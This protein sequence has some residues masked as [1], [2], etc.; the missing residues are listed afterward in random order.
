MND[1]TPGLATADDLELE[2]LNFDT[3]YDE[4]IAIEQAKQQLRPRFMIIERSL[5]AQFPDLS[6]VK[7]S[8]EI[9]Y[10][11]FITAMDGLDDGDS[12]GQMDALLTLM[13]P[14]QA[15]QIRS[16]GFVAAMAFT[17]KFFECWQKLVGV[18]DMGESKSSSH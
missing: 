13:G 9:P 11:K 18:A 3:P 1:D 2:L 7:V 17:V 15:D 10:E 16:K 4:D 5:A 8:F 14:R 6:R 12:I